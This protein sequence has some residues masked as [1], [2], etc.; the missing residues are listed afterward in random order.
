MKRLSGSSLAPFVP[1]MKLAFSLLAASC[2]LV[3]LGVGQAD[4]ASFN[5]ARASAPDERAICA[6]AGLSSTDD[7]L[8]GLYARLRKQLS[9]K[10]R[11]DL[12]V[13]QHEWLQRRAKCRDNFACLV[14]VYGERAEQLRA[15]LAGIN[16][17]V[18]TEAT[19]AAG[20]ILYCAARQLEVRQV[21]IASPGMMQTHAFFGVLNHGSKPCILRAGAVRVW[22]NDK[23][24]A[25][26]RGE[27]LPSKQ[28]LY[29]WYLT[30]ADRSDPDSQT[31]YVLPPVPP[32]WEVALKDLIGF[33]IWNSDA[34]GTGEWFSSISVQLPDIQ[35][36]PMGRVYKTEYKGYASFPIPK[37][38]VGLMPFLAWEVTEGVSCQT[39]RTVDVRL[40][41]QC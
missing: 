14:T 31:R 23:P 2:L 17:P 15:S 28:T 41:L 32:D 3:S 11:A 8:A 10:R 38:R 25:P 20:R 35:G 21:A 22:S 19:A 6:G 12:A 9:G 33:P 40:T 27:A 7:Q 26:I 29:K 37:M 30:S 16:A 24:P 18:E 4:A 36:R 39:A 34:S 1:N 13:S 5:C